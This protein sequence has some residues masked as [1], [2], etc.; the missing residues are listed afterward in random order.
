MLLIYQLE[1]EFWH[2][3]SIFIDLAKYCLKIIYVAFSKNNKKVGSV[4]TS[5]VFFSSSTEPTRNGIKTFQIIL[6]LSY[7]IKFYG[8]YVI[9]LLVRKCGNRARS[10][11]PMSRKI[12]MTRI[13]SLRLITFSIYH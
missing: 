4:T 1:Y 9:S 3:L 12:E 5:S 10:A 8:K 7:Q 11:S 6:S 13:R 2:P